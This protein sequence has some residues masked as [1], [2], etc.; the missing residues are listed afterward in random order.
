MSGSSAW[1]VLIECIVWLYECMGAWF[2][3]G[4]M[5]GTWVCG[6]CVV[7][8]C[9]VWKCLL[10]VW[11]FVECVGVW[12]PGQWFHTSCECVCKYVNVVGWECSELIEYHLLNAYLLLVLKTT[13]C[14][15]ALTHFITDWFIS[16]A[17]LSFPLDSLDYIR[18]HTHPRGIPAVPR[19]N[20]TLVITCDK[21]MYGR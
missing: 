1:W 19:P 15:P 21:F 2:V 20:F 8:V 12:P 5:V 4:R 17:L 7:S 14:L 11:V 13:I 18:T 3:C 16:H 9:R 6:E 10:N